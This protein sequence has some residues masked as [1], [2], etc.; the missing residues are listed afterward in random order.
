MKKYKTLFSLLLMALIASGIAGAETVFVTGEAVNIRSGPNTKHQVV[1]KVKRNEALKRI[2]RLDGWARVIL[3]DGETGWIFEKY[4]S[5]EGPNPKAERVYVSGKIVNIRSG[6]G[7]RHKI[8][9]EVEKGDELER[10]ERSNGWSEVKLHDGTT[11]WIHEKYI[12]KSGA[13]HIPEDPVL[14]FRSF[15]LG[16]E[17]KEI[18]RQLDEE[19][20]RFNL[21]NDE[22][23]AV[24]KELFGHECEII[25]HF[26]PKSMNLYMLELLWPQVD[27][28]KRAGQILIY[29][30]GEPERIDA[31][32]GNLFWFEGD[33]SV[34]L[35]TDL[36]ETRIYYTHSK[37]TELFEKE[38]N[39]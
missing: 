23:H 13:M 33:I 16:S 25:F 5:S 14:Q 8:L 4:I 35:D 10:I 1:R 39:G 2:K 38:S 36:R 37:L 15:R 3:S 28:S 20:Y 19:G 7:T 21:V 22:I 6:P 24:L 9:T 17:K 27:I 29:K 12:S 34:K 11:G 31:Q 26:T 32:T 30:Y 18:L